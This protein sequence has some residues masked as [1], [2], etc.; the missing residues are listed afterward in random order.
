MWPTRRVAVA[1]G[2]ALTTKEGQATD[3]KK[4][5][6]ENVVP[7]GGLNPVR[8]DSTPLSPPRCAPHAPD[9][10][11]GLSTG[12][13]KNDRSSRSSD[14]LSKEEGIFLV[15]LLSGHLR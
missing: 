5:K 9:G 8:Y 7:A 6:K 4:E 1:P 13:T 15:Q 3:K 11:C 12:P 2:A 10:A 14:D